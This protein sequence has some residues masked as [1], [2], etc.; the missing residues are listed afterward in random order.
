METMTF[1]YVPGIRRSL[2]HFADPSCPQPSGRAGGHHSRM[3]LAVE[4]QQ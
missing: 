1:K 2:K 3:L 4:E